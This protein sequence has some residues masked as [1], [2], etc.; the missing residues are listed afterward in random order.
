MKT[1]KTRW[2]PVNRCA[3]CKAIL[4]DSEIAYS[5]GVCPRC[6]NIS[7]TELVETKRIAV[8]KIT[9]APTFH[10]WLFKG[11]RTQVVYEEKDSDGNTKFL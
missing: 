3:K 8:R 1:T 9:H 4:Y 2:H 11:L 5:G 6:G 7:G 10:E